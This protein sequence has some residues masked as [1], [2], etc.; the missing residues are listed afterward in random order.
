MGGRRFFFGDRPSVCDLYSLV[1]YNWGYRTEHPM[2]E[3]PAFTAL[4]NEL[5]ARPGVRRALEREESPLLE[6][7]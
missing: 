2:R 4:K 7:P 6:S 1:F 3:L 5:L